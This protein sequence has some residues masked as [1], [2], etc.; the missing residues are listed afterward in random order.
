MG[1]FNFWRNW[2]KK[3]KTARKNIERRPRKKSAAKIAKKNE[4]KPPKRRRRKITAKHQRKKAG[5]ALKKLRKKTPARKYKKPLKKIGRVRALAK[6]KPPATREVEIG[7]ITHYFSKIS[8][9]IIKLRASLKVGE[10]IHVKGANDDFTQVV[11]SMQCDHQN[12]PRAASGMEIG[13]RVVRPVREN[14]KVY[15]ISL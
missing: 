3:K 4:L 12:I 10:E 14:D 9:G 1:L 6:V 15:R 7:S 13:V 8:V 5:P 11:D 2:F